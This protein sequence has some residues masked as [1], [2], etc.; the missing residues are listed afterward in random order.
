MRQIFRIAIV[1]LGVAGMIFLPQA[2]HATTY[3]CGQFGDSN[4]SYFDGFK[5]DSAAS[6][7]TGHYFEGVSSQVTV[8]SG[9]FCSPDNTAGNRSGS[10]TMIADGQAGFAQIGY[11]RSP[12][13][14]NRTFTEFWKGTGAIPDPVYYASVSDGQVRQYWE[15]FDGA[16]LCEHL[17]L[18]T[19]RVASTN[20]DPLTYWTHFPWQPQFAD[21]QGWAETQVSG[22]AGFPN[23]FDSLQFQDYYTDS[24]AGAPC[25]L[26]WID[27]SSLWGASHPT[28]DKYYIFNN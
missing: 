19:T 18:G 15:Q 20:F 26:H 3:T 22:T 1:W 12:G 16:C 4:G 5:Y 10:Y 2:A 17:N 7:Y 27:Q 8:R 9:T 25:G 14:A 11:A 13:I 24:F 23:I 21:E 6:G 28:C